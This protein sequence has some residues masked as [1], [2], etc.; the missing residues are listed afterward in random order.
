[1][2]RYIDL[3]LSSLGGE[4]STSGKLKLSLTPQKCVMSGAGEVVANEA[5]AVAEQL[6]KGTERR[7]WSKM[8][9]STYFHSPDPLAVES[10]SSNLRSMYVYMLHLQVLIFQ[11]SVVAGQSQE[12]TYSE[13]GSRKGTC[14]RKSDF[15]N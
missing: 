2:Q 11:F 14:T 10:G 15:R 4:N 7:L 13:Q 1:M 6:E 5:L 9:F 8:K 12:E 3:L